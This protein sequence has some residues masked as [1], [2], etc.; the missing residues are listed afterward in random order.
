MINLIALYMGYAGILLILM[1]ALIFIF[2]YQ[3]CT[4]EFPG[5]FSIFGFGYIWTKDPTVIENLRKVRKDDKAGFEIGNYVTFFTAPY[6]FNEHV[7]N[8]G[9]SK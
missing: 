2:S 7:C 5:L 6:W 3:Q 8:I 4:S 1:V 9:G